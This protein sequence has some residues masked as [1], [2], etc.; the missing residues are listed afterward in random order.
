MVSECFSLTELRLWPFTQ[1]KRRLRGVQRIVIY[2]Y[3]CKSSDSACPCWECISCSYLNAVFSIAALTDQYI[4]YVFASKCIHLSPISSICAQIP[5]LW[6]FKLCAVHIKVQF[7]GN[8]MHPN[9]MHKNIRWTSQY[10]VRK[11]WSG[12]YWVDGWI[13]P[14]M[15]IGVPHLCVIKSQY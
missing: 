11:S 2:K 8:Q 9:I 6:A 15:G 1:L 4:K 12:K 14:P 13:K 5:Q 7:C 3:H 10:Q